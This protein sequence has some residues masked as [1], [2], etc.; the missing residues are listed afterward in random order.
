MLKEEIQVKWPCL[1][2]ILLNAQYNPFYILLSSY[3]SFYFLKKSVFCRSFLSMDCVKKDLVKKLF[4]EHYFP[5]LKK[6]TT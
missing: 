6:K 3:R 1:A 4:P 2:W 5:K